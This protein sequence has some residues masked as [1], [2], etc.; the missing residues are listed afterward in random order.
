M[1]IYPEL[2]KY[3]IIVVAFILILLIIRRIIKNC[4]LII[5][6]KTKTS[7]PI[8]CTEVADSAPS[9]IDNEE[10]V[11]TEISE[12]EPVSDSSPTDKTASS[13]RLSEEEQKTQVLLEAKEIL[14]S[15]QKELNREPHKDN[16]ASSKDE[17]GAESRIEKFY[18]HYI[19]ILNNHL[20]SQGINCSKVT[21]S[22]ATTTA[23]K[24]QDGSIDTINS[25]YRFECRGMVF[26]FPEDGH[27]LW[28]EGDINSENEMW[29]ESISQKLI[30]KEWFRDSRSYLAVLAT[31]T[32][33]YALMQ[34]GDV[35]STDPDFECPGLFQKID[36][37]RRICCELPIDSVLEK[38]ATLNYI[39]D[40]K[41]HYSW[42]LK[43]FISSYTDGSYDTGLYEVESSTSKNHLLRNYIVDIDLYAMWC[44][45]MN[46]TVP[47]FAAYDCLPEDESV[48][49]NHRHLLY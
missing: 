28:L 32:E 41:A 49:Y 18:M 25:I 4:N 21:F 23:K 14:Q 24:V 15:R 3:A 2:E 38:A 46:S 39:T 12:S 48:N 36:E 16:S 34:S 5:S 11:E 9:N 1:N 19:E 37:A 22:Q 35:K 7:S 45:V 27:Y 10:T 42:Y 20:I 29:Y 13:K 44:D 40:L 6:K 47:N 30:T 26:I 8:V 43:S 31:E 33:I 17:N